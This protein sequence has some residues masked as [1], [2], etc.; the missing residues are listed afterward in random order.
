MG[1]VMPL[2]KKRE[3]YIRKLHS[4]KVV[5]TDVFYDLPNT[6]KKIFIQ[7]YVNKIVVDPIVDLV[8]AIDCKKHS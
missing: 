5:A 2:D 8:L 3:G 6:Q 1:T 4:L 7:N